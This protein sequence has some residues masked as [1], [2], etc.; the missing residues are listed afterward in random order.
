MPPRHRYALAIVALVLFILA[1]M[2]WGTGTGVL[3]PSVPGPAQKAADRPEVG[4]GNIILQ[5]V[6][7]QLRPIAGVAIRVRDQTADTTADGRVAF[8]DVPGGDQVARAEGWILDATTVLQVIPGE[9]KEYV[10]HLTRD[11]AGPVQL[12]DLY[13]E[14][15]AGFQVTIDAANDSQL[16]TTDEKGRV[17]FARRGC[18]GW[19]QVALPDGRVYR[20][21]GRYEVRGSEPINITLS[22]KGWT[23]LVRLVNASGEVLNGTVRGPFATSDEGNGVTATYSSVPVVRVTG[24][25]DGYQS[26]SVQVPADS[27]VHDVLMKRPRMVQVHAI[28]EEAGCPTALRC[29]W[30][31]CE[32]VGPDYL[33]PCNNGLAPND[34]TVDDWHGALDQVPAGA[35]EVE[36]DLRKGSASFMGTWTGP[37]PCEGTISSAG[38][39]HLGT[40][41]PVICEPDGKFYSFGGMTAGVWNVT[42]NGADAVAHRTVTLKA[43]EQKQLGNVGPDRL[44]RTMGTSRQQSPQPAPLTGRSPGSTVGAGSW[45]RMRRGRLRSP[46]TRIRM[47]R[48]TS[49]AQRPRGRRRHASAPSPTQTCTPD[50]SSSRRT[51]GC[52]PACGRAPRSTTCPRGAG[53]R[54]RRRSGSR[55]CP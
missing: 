28:C 38:S 25:A 47:T 36:V 41:F 29:D 19:V 34:L 39:T 42:M 50:H 8:D 51:R 17:W 20:P 15:A 44:V 31:P 33:C 21:R 23:A 32:G 54:S 30:A 18:V 49:T 27:I 45:S 13:G 14:A 26:V 24:T 48:R 22:S 10:V 5:A 55:A 46:G 12:T 16:L 37:L 52:A 35:T 6:D 1:L 53:S 11:C 43:G 9:T 2:V 40:A 3:K 4:R 7:A